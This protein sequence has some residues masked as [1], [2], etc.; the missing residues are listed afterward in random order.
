MKSQ[1]EFFYILFIVR[2]ISDNFIIAYLSKIRITISIKVISFSDFL[3]DYFSKLNYFI[4]KPYNKN[5]DPNTIAKLNSLTK[6]N[7]NEKLS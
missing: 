5:I 4:S 2:P 6:E 1:D 3:N 7:T